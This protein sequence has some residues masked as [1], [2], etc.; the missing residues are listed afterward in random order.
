MQ[1]ECDQSLNMLVASGSREPDAAMGGRPRAAACQWERDSRLQACARCACIPRGARARILSTDVAS[2]PH[3]G[4]GICTEL[5]AV[6]RKCTRFP[7][8]CV[9]ANEECRYCAACGH[10]TRHC[11][12]FCTPAG[13]LRESALVRSAVPADRRAGM[14]S[15]A[16][17]RHS[18]EVPVVMRMQSQA[19]C[20][21]LRC[22]GRPCACIMHQGSP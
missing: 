14:A 9:F 21:L 11:G 17:R 7:R 8:P 22:R 4:D 5:D 15:C 3:K 1:C 19:A 20:K 16:G 2:I 10:R 12:A 18:Y 13:E 6:P